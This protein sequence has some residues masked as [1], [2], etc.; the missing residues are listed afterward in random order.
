MRNQ[1]DLRSL[2]LGIG[3]SAREDDGIGWSFVDEVKKRNIF[4][5]DYLYTYQL[6]LEEV[7]L[8]LQYHRVI[9]VDAFK[10]EL[11]NGFCFRECLPDPNSGFSTHLL[12]AEGL[13]YLSQ[14]LFNYLP[15]AY[16]LSIQGYNWELNEQISAQGLVNL[17]NALVWFNKY[18][19]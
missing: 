10:G 17:K 15:Q 9:F 3:N 14:S 13:L 7:E 18:I 16:M 2:L 11:T 1:D 6:N 5:G 12:S 4:K 19:L 8:L